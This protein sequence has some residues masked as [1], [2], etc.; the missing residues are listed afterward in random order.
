MIPN[1]ALMGPLAYLKGGITSTRLGYIDNLNGLVASRLDTTISSRASSTAL[2]TVDANVDAI[3]SDTSAYLDAT[4]SSRLSACA[5]IS[6]SS[7]VSAS[8]AASHSTGTDLTYYDVTTATFLDYHKVI[9]FGIF[10]AS[11]TAG[12]L[13]QKNPSGS[14]VYDAYARQTAN[15]TMRIFCPWAS[16]TYIGGVFTLVEFY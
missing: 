5:R 16:L 14:L 12:I 3:L 13:G 1:E 15:S 7:F 9:P 4:I 8:T 11:D 10:S 2:A 6:W